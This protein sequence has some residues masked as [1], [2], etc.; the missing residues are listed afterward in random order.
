MNRTHNLIIIKKCQFVLAFIILSSLSNT[1]ESLT[2]QEKFICGYKHVAE[3]INSLISLDRDLTLNYIERLHRG[4]IKKVDKIHLITILMRYRLF[5]IN[6]NSTR[7]CRFFNYL[8]IPDTDKNIFYELALRSLNTQ[9]D[10]LGSCYISSRGREKKISLF[11]TDCR[12]A[13]EKRIRPV[14]PPFAITQAGVESGW[15]TSR[16]SIKGNNFFGI[17]TVFSSTKKTR[18]KK[19]CIPARGDPRR[20][21]YNFN[22]IENGFFIYFQL[23]N[24][25]TP[26][27][28][29]RNYR[30]R[31]ESMS[32][33]TSCEVSLQMARG[34]SNYA[35]DPHYVQKIQ[36]TIKTVCQIIDNC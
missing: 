31:F 20:C 32:N 35:E 11:S 12:L 3:Y 21:V 24:S 9:P 29:L 30:Y 22:S 7:Q 33:T 1:S 2:R 14:P 25:A 5:P 10:D 26:Y 15:G 17:Q 27:I 16:F 4:K 19:Q 23:L 36:N 13:I 28:R 8:C 6:Q 18:N 34:L